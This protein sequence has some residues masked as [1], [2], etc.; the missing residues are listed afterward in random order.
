[1]AAK[2]LEGL[3][4]EMTQAQIVEAQRIARDRQRKSPIPI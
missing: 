1:M 4:V 2:D 3:A